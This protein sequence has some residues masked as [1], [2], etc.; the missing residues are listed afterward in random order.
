MRVH[1][2]SK[3]LGL[4]NRDLLKLLRENGIPA[5]S[6]MSSLEEED[7]ITVRRA[8]ALKP[9]TPGEAAAKP[10][11]PKE[12]EPE[13]K[14]PAE[15]TA[16]EP[17]TQTKPEKKEP[18]A[19]VPAVTPA[20]PKTEKPAPVVA[21]KP[22]TPTKAEPPKAPAATP[23]K[24]QQSPAIK[25]HAPKES[26]TSTAPATTK[27]PVKEHQKVE[28]PKPPPPKTESLK[29]APPAKTPAPQPPAAKQ[30]VEAPEDKENTGTGESPTEAAEVLRFR[31]G[32]IVRELADL[33]KIK[34]NQ[35]VAILM[36]MNVFATI[37][38]KLDFDVAEKVAQHFGFEVEHEKKSDASA[39]MPERPDPD[40]PV[41]DRPEDLVPRP[42]VVT[43]LG[44]VDHGKTSLMDQ[45]RKTSVVKGESGGITQHIGAYSVDV[46]GHSITFLDT[47]GHAAFT[48][49][50]ARGANLTDIAVIIIAADDGIMPQTKE[51]I[52]HAKAADVAIMI[53][54]NKC[55]LPAANP[56][57]VMQQLQAEGLTPEDWGGETICCKVSAITGEGIEHLLEMI[58]LQA[59]VQELCANPR[60]PA[61]GYI[62]E[63][64]MLPGMG[65]TATMLVTGGTL[66]VGD[67]VLCG[68][69]WG[70]ARALIDDRGNKIKSAG[71]SKPVKCLGLSGVPEAGAEFHVVSN[72]RVAKNR[73]AEV[74]LTRKTASLEAPRKVSLDDF[75]SQSEDDA[76]RELSLIVKADTQGSVEAIVQSLTDIKSE[77]VSARF[78]HAGTGNITTNDVLLAS[79]SNA[80]VLGFHV[81]KETGVD[82]V[83]KREGV[84]VRLHSIIYELIDQV[85]DAMIGVLGPRMEEAKRGQAQVRQIFE[86]G[87]GHKVG[88]CLVL[89]GI[90]NIKHRVRVKRK[91]EVLY[92]GTLLSLKHFQEDAKEVREAQECG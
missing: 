64:E 36:K 56:D 13:P 44:H 60:K 63:A 46:A 3:E 88:G 40:A 43:F 91:T 33:M 59:E 90:V 77:K 52:A 92:E 82:A 22:A 85:R 67:A 76:K 15:K 19:E 72:D 24:T 41:E 25:T 61:I 12:S 73:S 42:P 51:A 29:P 16:T 9:V 89:K 74:A 18:V 84:E 65:P 35:I 27:A 62:V 31:G 17:A 70:R 1:E 45:I 5:K 80:V 68:Q 20:A 23:G 4:E 57:R 37:N 30:A 7:L 39:A 83:A 69:H 48:A 54:I 14:T 32:I 50:R 55:D 79:A 26:S 47:P 53:A 11:A 28:S 71:P 6:H 49:M 87:K 58:L 66:K 75:F 86:V 10:A 81:A 38:A 78:I 21:A 2:L 8:L 34:P